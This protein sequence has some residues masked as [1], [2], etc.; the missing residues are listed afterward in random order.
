MVSIGTILYTLYLRLMIII[1]FIIF[2]IPLLICLLL[3]RRFIVDNPFFII[4]TKIFYWCCVKFSFLPIHYK[5][6]ENIPHEPCII[7]AN[8]QSSYDIPLIGYALKARPH[9]WLAWAALEK[10][11]LIGFLVKR[12]AVLVDMTSPIKGLRTLVQAINIVTEHPWDLIIFPEGGRYI[13]GKIH[14]FFGGFS[15]L[16]KKIGRPIVPMKISGADTAYPPKTFWMHYN[17]ISLTIGQPMHM[18]PGETE[19]AFKDRVYNWFIT[20]KE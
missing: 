10:G 19:E 15:T 4:L 13:D 18:E 9:V 6:I 3:P 5:G 12:I 11:P 16:A 7:V 14:P 17:P 1:L 8:H 2:V 20:H